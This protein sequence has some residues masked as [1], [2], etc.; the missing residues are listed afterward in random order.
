[1]R[2]KLIQLLIFAIPLFLCANLTVQAQMNGIINTGISGVAPSGGGGVFG[3]IGLGDENIGFTIGAKTLIVYIPNDLY[4]RFYVWNDEF[5]FFL[6]AGGWFGPPFIDYG[7]DNEYD[8]YN[9]GEDRVAAGAL[10][11][12]QEGFTY[13]VYGMIGLRIENFLFSGGINHEYS[14]GL[15]Q[16]AFS[17]EYIIDSY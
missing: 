14:M 6:L 12:K 15:T 2:N 7:W 16:P 4:M 8:Y 17:V 3:E 10:I 9:N 13:A 1:M 5:G 11:N